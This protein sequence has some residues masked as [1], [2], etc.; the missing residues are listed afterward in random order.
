[1]SIMLILLSFPQNSLSQEPKV[2]QKAGTKVGAPRPHFFA[3]KKFIGCVA[4]LNVA[5]RWVVEHPNWSVHFWDAHL[6]SFDPYMPI[7]REHR[8]FIVIL[9]CSDLFQ[10]PAIASFGIESR[11]CRLTQWHGLDIDTYPVLNNKQ[12]LLAFVG[13]LNRISGKNQNSLISCLAAW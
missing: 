13:F 8:E 10:G 9:Y 5:P 3:G 7:K 6:S 12:E 2:L 4:K 1:M 11:I